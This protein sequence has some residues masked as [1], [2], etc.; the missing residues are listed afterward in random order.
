MNK[1]LKQKRQFKCFLCDDCINKKYV[2]GELT[3][4]GIPLIDTRNEEI[5]YRL[6]KNFKYKKAYLHET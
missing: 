1:K 6:C 5:S 4:D 3:C 2:Y